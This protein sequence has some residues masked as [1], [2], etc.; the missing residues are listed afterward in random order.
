MAANA[1]TPPP[2]RHRRTIAHAPRAH[3][4]AQGRLLHSL[5]CRQQCGAQS[6]LPNP[7]K[8]VTGCIS[9]VCTQQAATAHARSCELFGPCGPLHA[10]P[11]GNIICPHPHFGWLSS[12][13]GS[14]AAQLKAASS[15]R[16]SSKQEQKQ[17][18]Q[19]QQQHQQAAAATAT[20]AN[21]NAAPQQPQRHVGSAGCFRPWP[22]YI[23]SPSHPP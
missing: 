8:V 17:P 19:Q 16:S 22:R 9:H 21:N 15:S 18:Q 10:M 1:G 5:Y 12:S 20:A 4:R 3:R 23:W 6:F 7:E 2:C 11:S 14:E 13:C